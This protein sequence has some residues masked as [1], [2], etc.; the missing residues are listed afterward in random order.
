MD[1]Q[2]I[3]IFVCVSCRRPT[4][5]GD[6]AADRPGPRLVEALEAGLAAQAPGGVAVTAVECL[7]VCKRPCTVALS[8][9]GKWTYLI[10]DLDPETHAGEIVSAALAFAASG[11]GILPWRERPASFRKGVIARV[12]PP[13]FKG[14]PS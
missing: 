14:F 3:T 6:A 11:N 5:E 1:D 4:E 2:G 9:A 13:A 12:P 10:G 7:A 8:A